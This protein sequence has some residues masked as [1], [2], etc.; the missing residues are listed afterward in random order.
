MFSPLPALTLLAWRHLPTK[1]WVGPA[2][3]AALR[4]AAMALV[5]LTGGCASLPGDV[6]RPV[7]AAFGD[8][9]ATSLARTVAA[10]ARDAPPDTSGFRLLPDGG[11]AFEARIALVRRAE[12]SVDAQYYL[13]AADR[14]GGQFLA[15]L[16]AAAARGVRVRLLVDDLN[17]AGQ[18]GVFE[19]LAAR[20][21]VE[22]RLFNPLPAR[23]GS[24]ATRVVL[25]L[26][27]LGRINR[28]MHNKL[29][30]AD[31]SMAISG[32]RNIADEYFDR[33]GTAHFI[34]L[35]LLSAGPVVVE[36]SSGFDLFWN[37]ALAY[38]VASLARRPS[39]A[40]DAVAASPA[41]SLALSAFDS[42]LATGRLA[43][44][45]APARVLVD[46]MAQVEA[47]SPAR[48]DS[49][50]MNAHLELVRTASSSVLMASP[51]FVPGRRGLQALGEARARDVS[52][53][54]VTNSLATTDEPLAHFGYARYRVELLRIGVALHELVAGGE[55]PPARDRG[56]GGD[57]QGGSGSG[58]SLGRL[59]A[60]VVVVDERWV[61]VGSMNMDR[62]SAR[63]NSESAVLID[64]PALA[65]EVAAFLGRDLGVDSYRLRLGDD[66]AVEWLRGDGGAAL[67]KEPRRATRVGLTRRLASFFVSDDWL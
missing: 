12:R 33:S 44:H 23:R 20:P 50:V 24:F 67:R 4:A 14:S 55:A 54:V 27:E 64:S 34:D 41:P 5:M 16:A 65:A 35:D 51:Y 61:S 29:L 10:S 57:A 21:H 52:L 47:S 39:G 2:C 19:A 66:G 30:I 25:S 22:V 9:A 3:V 13:V 1:V 17:A 60:K 45:F 58:A 43:L 28:R 32:G 18:D 37:S 26:H 11:G 59:H 46:G 42:E 48:P 40:G 31:N 53:R 62:R 38:P 49:D 6:A 56:S 63:C 36:L 7:S 15:E 8:V